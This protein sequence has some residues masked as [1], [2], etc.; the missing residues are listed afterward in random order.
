MAGYRQCKVA[1]HLL[2]RFANTQHHQLVSNS[3]GSRLIFTNIY[4][5]VWPSWGPFQTQDPR[6]L[7][8]TGH[9]LPKVLCTV[10]FDRCV[11]YNFNLCL[12][13]VHPL[14]MTD[15]TA[16]YFC[17]FYVTNTCTM[18]VLYTFNNQYLYVQIKWFHSQH[19]QMWFFLIFD[20][21]LLRS[22][23]A[24]FVANLYCCNSFLLEFTYYLDVTLP[25]GNVPNDR[26]Q[27]NPWKRF[28]QADVRWMALWGHHFSLFGICVC[29]SWVCHPV[30]SSIWNAW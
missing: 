7:W 28:E 19:D 20:P 3:L 22:T 2:T 21:W 8:T 1:A 4:K 24:L 18:Y 29:P 12:T 23:L 27:T 9:S 5:S 17:F 6:G 16:M 11:F 13:S 30:P 15:G 25:W 26:A 10:H 14:K